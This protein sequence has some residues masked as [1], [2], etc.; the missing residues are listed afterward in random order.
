MLKHAL[1]FALLAAGISAS[2]IAH[3]ENYKFTIHNSSPYVISSF[4]A[5]EGDG[6][7]ANWLDG[8][9]VDSGQ[10]IPLQ[11]LRD[12]PC[13]IQVRVGWR[14]TDGG[15]QVGEPWNIDICKAENVYFDGENVTY[16]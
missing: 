7:S 6:W 11:F 15:Q 2:F 13:D 16:N 4:Q 3:A 14:T 12:G 10:S 1:R 8:L 9:Q 5:N